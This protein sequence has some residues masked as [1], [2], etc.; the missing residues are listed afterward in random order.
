MN[1]LSEINPISSPADAPRKVLCI[2]LDDASIG[3]I[4]PLIREG[5]Y[6]KALSFFDPPGK[7]KTEMDEAAIVFVQWDGVAKKAH[8]LLLSRENRSEKNAVPIH[9][10]LRNAAALAPL[11]PRQAKEL[12]ISGWI[13]LPQKYF[14]IER[15]IYD[16]AGEPEAEDSPPEIVPLGRQIRQPAA[17]KS[18]QRMPEAGSSDE[19]CLE[20]PAMPELRI[21]VPSGADLEIALRNIL[22]VWKKANHSNKLQRPAK[23]RFTAERLVVVHPDEAFGTEIS[24][25]LEECG[26]SEVRRPRSVDDT[27]L[28][29][30]R[31]AT[32]LI[33]WFDGSSRLIYSV[34]EHMTESR[35]LTFVP[36]LVLLPSRDVAEALGTKLRGYFF[37][38][39]AFYDRKKETLAKALEAMQNAR[40]ATN[41][42]RAILEQMR[43]PLK[44]ESPPEMRRSIPLADL[45][46]LAQKVMDRPGKRYWGVAELI[47]HLVL[48]G[49]VEKAIGHLREAVTVRPNAYNTLVLRTL[50]ARQT[51]KKDEITL[52]FAQAV[53]KYPDLT[54]DRLFRA[55]LMLERWKAHQALAVLLNGWSEHPTHRADSQL[56]WMAGKY[57][58]LAHDLEKAYAFMSHAA[59][60][61][62]HRTDYA[63]GLAR[64]F[65]ST[66]QYDRAAS[67]LR[68]V[69]T[70]RDCSWDAKVL[71]PHVL[72]QS[73]NIKEAHDIVEQLLTRAPRNHELLQLK[74]KLN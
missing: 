65:A 62:P 43:R 4:S 46:S 58:L 33:L 41:T 35:Q 49:E 8:K 47:P 32:G 1:A 59:N 68:F 19:A 15:L 54:A 2:G 39:I 36:I 16:L 11:T 42:P 13:E 71:L 64:I 25:L 44:L 18:D 53:L 56:F 37:D 63:E 29:M 55:A 45:E 3:I 72:F 30:R 6:L 34:L 40:D 74:T 52:A 20:V 50:V 73:R 7:I 67:I 24:M 69:S 27:M 57:Y 9:M 26:V 14:E 66:L 60:L 28:E 23:G 51:P 70:A 5:F 17:L 12:E 10:I 61:E 31:G 48:N 21:Q 22:A 38:A